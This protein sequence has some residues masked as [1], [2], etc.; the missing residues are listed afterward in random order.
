MVDNLY[1]EVAI[2]LFTLSLV[3]NWDGIS[4]E[5]NELAGATSQTF[6]K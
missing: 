1:H 6:E 4:T 2:Q 5:G 3:M